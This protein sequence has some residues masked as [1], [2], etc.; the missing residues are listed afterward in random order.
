MT[1]SGSIAA[2]TPTRNAADVL[3]AAGSAMES[4]SGDW[5]AVAAA[6]LGALGVAFAAFWFA[7]RKQ[8]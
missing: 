5:I 2:W 4:P 6:V 1:S 3:I 8:T 7:A